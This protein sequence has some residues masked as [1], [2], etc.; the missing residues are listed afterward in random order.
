[1]KVSIPKE[2]IEEIKKRYECDEPKAIK[3]YLDAKKVSEEAFDDELTRQLG[4]KA[5]EEKWQTPIYTP[6]QIKDHL[7]KYVIGQEKY[8]KRLSIA[9]AF[10]FAILHHLYENPEET[11]VKRFRKKN[12]II[13]GPSG[14]GKTYSVEVLGDLLEVPTLIVDATDYTEAGLLNHHEPIDDCEPPATE[15]MN[16]ALA[17]IGDCLEKGHGVAVHCLEGRGRTGTVLGAWLALKESLS[18]EDAIKRI[19]DLR[20]GTIITP[21]QR[22]FLHQYLNGTGREVFP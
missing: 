17:F 7:D 2:E 21:S 22:S 15:G 13:S 8:K 11:K 19:H 3:A 6:R 1:M 14:S 10:H 9:S 12:T 5:Q 16:R 20:E 4:P 18:P